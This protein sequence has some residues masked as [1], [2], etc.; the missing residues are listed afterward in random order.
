MNNFIPLFESSTIYVNFNVY[1]SKT[2]AIDINTPEYDLY[3]HCSSFSFCYSENSASAIKS[4]IRNCDIKKLCAVNCTSDVI[5]QPGGALLYIYNDDIENNNIT[6][7]MVSYS[8][9]P[10]NNETY[11]SV[12]LYNGTTNINY[13]NSSK[14]T[15]SSCSLL[16]VRCDIAKKSF[17]S[18]INCV[19]CM[20]VNSLFFNN[21]GEYT[22]SNINF[23]NNTCMTKAN[24]LIR[25]YGDLT[26]KNSIFLDNVGN[27]LNAV[28]KESKISFNKCYFDDIS[29]TGSGKI[30]TGNSIYNSQTIPMKEITC[31]IFL[32]CTLIQKRRPLFLNR[33]GMFIMNI[34]P[35]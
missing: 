17:G 25:T 7:D 26:F 1:Y 10:V 9:T 19:E 4:L 29:L 21:I 24:G 34:L 11:S 23:I 13:I 31:V 20:S 8:Y 33:I 12:T 6:L 15:A 27:L 32:K 22:Y 18:F 5:E 2:S 3:V 16:Y 30:I 28:T 35:K 14:N